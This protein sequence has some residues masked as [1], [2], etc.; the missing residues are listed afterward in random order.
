MNSLLTKQTKLAYLLLPHFSGLFLLFPFFC[1]H[2]KFFI[3]ANNAVVSSGLVYLKSTF[4]LQKRRGK[5][6][7][8]HFNFF[9][10][11]H[12]ISTF[13]VLHS[14]F[15]SLLITLFS[16]SWF[17]NPFSKTSLVIIHSSVFYSHAS[18]R[19]AFTSTSFHSSI[20]LLLF[21]FF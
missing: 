2:I 15:S 7:R 6:E 9:L 11:S 1:S 16:F 20:R 12:C 8:F 10:V 3:T 14:C 18:S 5:I 17:L 13:H 21:F 4:D 19:S